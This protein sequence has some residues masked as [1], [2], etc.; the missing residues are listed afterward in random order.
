MNPIYLGAANNDLYQEIL[1][2]HRGKTFAEVKEDGYRIQVH[3]K[4]N[5]TLGFTRSGNSVELA[6]FPEV[7]SSLD[8]LPDCIID[9][10]LVGDGKVGH[11]GFDVIKR[12]FR[13]RI[14]KEGIEKYLESGICKELPVGLVVFDS[15]YWENQPLVNFP[16]SRRREYTEKVS[17]R[18]IH[19]SNLTIISSPQE[20]QRRFEQLVNNYYEGLVCKNPNSLYLPGKRTKD[21]IKL[22]RSESLDLT[23]LGV[24]LEDNKISQILC[25]TYNEPLARYES[26]CKVNAKREGLDKKLY[27]LLEQS[28]LKECPDNVFLNP[29]IYKTEGGIPDFFVDPSALL[30]EVCSMNFHRTNNWHSCGYSEKKSYSLRIAWL[31]GIREDKSVNDVATTEQVGVLYNNENGE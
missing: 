7:R 3:K 11:E 31:K 26:L 27:P 14:S 21:W 17:E 19:P 15:L 5:K 20:L 30:V 28:F 13:H 23:V 9:C 22:K 1:K 6:L 8:N 12:R 18:K 2:E 29:K 10:E 16:L 4:G 24:Y 25:G